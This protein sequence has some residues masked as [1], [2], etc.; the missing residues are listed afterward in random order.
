MLA[1]A[2]PAP[3]ALIVMGLYFGGARLLHQPAQEKVADRGALCDAG[4]QRFK[5]HLGWAGRSTPFPEALAEPDQPVLD[6]AH[7]RRARPRARDIVT[8][9]TPCKMLVQ[10]PGGA[11]PALALGRDVNSAIP[12]V[13]CWFVGWV[14]P[15]ETHHMIDGFVQ[16]NL[17]PTTRQEQSHE[18]AKAKLRCHPHAATN[19]DRPG[20]SPEHAA[21]TRL[22]SPATQS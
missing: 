15:C 6:A 19:L 7:A 4:R 1:S 20:R 5:A 16:P 8:V 3:A 9:S 17:D 13:V 10:R 12:P 2:P 18:I 11:V 21:S 14:E 22:P